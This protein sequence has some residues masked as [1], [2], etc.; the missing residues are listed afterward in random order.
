M[1]CLLLYLDDLEDLVYALALNGE[2]IRRFARRLGAV[3]IVVLSQ[4]A[5][6]MLALRA[7]E[8]GAGAAALLAV[9]ALCR[10]AT[11]PVVPRL[12]GA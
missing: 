9:F 12:Q 10:S 4:A 5:L 2:R 1:E 3:A 6:V 7:P 11:A 8:L